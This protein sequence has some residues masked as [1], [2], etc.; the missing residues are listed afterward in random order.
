MAW[1]ALASLSPVL[2]TVVACLAGG[3][4]SHVALAWVSVVVFAADRI[5]PV[6]LAP[7]EDDWARRA[8]LALSVTLGLAHFLLLALGI[9]ALSG[10]V[11]LG[12]AQWVSLTLA[13]GIFFGQISNSN[14]HELIH[15]SARWPRRLGVAIYVS[16]L[17]GHHVSA[18]L[19]VHHP[20]VASDR[21]PN[22]A[23]KGESFY[24]FW[25][26]AWRGSFREGWRAEN[27]LRARRGARPS[28]LS[29][30]YVVYVAGAAATM[31]AA[32]LIGGL[33]GVFTLLLLAL[34]AQAQ[35]MVSD[36]IQHYGLRRAAHPDG[37]LE[38]V[39]PAHSWNAAPWYS[40]A[41]MLNAPRHSDHHM[42]PGRAFAALSL[43]KDVP[44]LPSTFPV[45]GV[46]ATIPPLWRRIMDPRVDRV[47]QTVL[48]SR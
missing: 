35:L 22:S 23:R 32:G 6:E 44:M 8:G 3:G 2:V 17:F 39:G 30:P 4:W 43:G 18:H 46:V 20:Y 5:V 16:L 29:H 47:N 15:T 11:P 37:T 38:P 21:D 10:A 42:N 33:P 7:R 40:A 36:Y 24:R 25:I 14:A 26:R 45:M 13:L 12:A 28:R 31:A 48:T 19:R 34:Y 27:R 41:M 9:R 1:Y